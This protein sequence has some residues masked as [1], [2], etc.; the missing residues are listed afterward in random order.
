VVGY[1]PT[2]GMHSLTSKPRNV[3]TPWQPVKCQPYV[4]QI[5]TNTSLYKFINRYRKWLF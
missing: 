3:V 4:T 1:R 5:Y 2:V